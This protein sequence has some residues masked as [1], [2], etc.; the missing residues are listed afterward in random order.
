MDS[1]KVD[2]D[3]DDDEDNDDDDDA[4]D[5][6]D[7]DIT[8]DT[9]DDDDDEDIKDLTVGD[10]DSDSDG[11]DIDLMAAAETTALVPL[12]PARG[13]AG[14]VIAEAAPTRNK[15]VTSVTRLFM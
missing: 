6:G 5:L 12:N 2:D 14:R 11:A 7:F 9:D 10:L 8:L 15:D 4:E 3:S 13:Y 1:L